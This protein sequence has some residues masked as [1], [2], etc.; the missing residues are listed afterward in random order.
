MEKESNIVLLKGNAYAVNDERKFYG[1]EYLISAQRKQRTEEVFFVEGEQ[2]IR[3]L[4]HWIVE[5]DREHHPYFDVIAGGYK[6]DTNG[7]DVGVCIGWTEDVE[8]DRIIPNPD[9]FY[10]KDSP[11]YVSLVVSAYLKQHERK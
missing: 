5:L 8:T 11:P 10:S 1:D 4:F 9:L 7:E 3:I 6:Q 2:K